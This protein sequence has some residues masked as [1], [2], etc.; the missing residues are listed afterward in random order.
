MLKID[1]QSNGFFD[2]FDLNDGAW[3]GAL[4]RYKVAGLYTIAEHCG[5]DLVAETLRRDPPKEIRIDG[6]VRQVIGF[7]S[8]NT[9]G[10]VQL[11]VESKRSD[12][13]L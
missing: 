12:M 2:Y 6:E 10:C 11:T 5:S 4:C 8:R 3:C 9:N 13:S 7:V 1:H